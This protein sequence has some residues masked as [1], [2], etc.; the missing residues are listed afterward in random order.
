MDARSTATG[1]PA[2]AGTR[3]SWATGERLPIRIDAAR[4]VCLAL[5]LAGCSDGAKSDAGCDDGFVTAADGR[6]YAETDGPFGDGWTPARDSAPAVLVDT[7]DTAFATGWD[8]ADT[9]WSTGDSYVATGW[10]DS[11]DTDWGDTWWA[12]S[13]ET[14]LDT[15]WDTFDTY[16]DSGLVIDTSSVPQ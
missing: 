12:D 1:L 3:L 9:A 4:V 16:W 15:Y 5:A 7:A 8:S 2:E 6:C 13:A 14:D 10:V 11:S